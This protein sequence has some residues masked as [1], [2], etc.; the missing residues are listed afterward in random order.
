[1][2]LGPLENDPPQFTWRRFLW[3]MGN[4]LRWKCPTCG[5]RPLFVPWYKVR[6][7]Q[8]WFMPL[9]GCPTCGYPFDREPG[10][11]LLSIFAINYGVA[12]MLGLVVYL[13]LDFAMHLPIWLTLAITI[14]P[15]PFFNLWFARHSKALF[16]AFDLFCDPHQRDDDGGDQSVET[17]APRP[18]N[19]DHEPA[20]R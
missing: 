3:M 10:Y 6:S 15:I 12:S 8:D 4:A 20:E 17:P 19:P 16:I 2:W 1:M 9:D 14:A 7:L 13:L 18:Q 11:F 5:Q